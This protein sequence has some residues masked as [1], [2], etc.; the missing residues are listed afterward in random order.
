MIHFVF[1]ELVYYLLKCLYYFDL[2]MFHLIHR[3][4]IKGS[5]TNLHHIDL[6]L[7]YNCLFHWLG[8]LDKFEVRVVAPVQGKKG[9]KLMPV[10]L[11]A[12]CLEQRIPED[13]HL[14]AI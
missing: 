10:V 2:K 5:P 8:T 4:V 14:T 1:F 6:A 13:L 11:S 7:P 9:L 12:D 3:L